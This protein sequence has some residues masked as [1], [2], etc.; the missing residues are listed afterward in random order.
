[1]RSH[2]GFVWLLVTLS[3]LCMTVTASTASAQVAAVSVSPQS[4]QLGSEVEVTATRFPAYS[5]VR[6][7]F[8]TSAG[9]TVDVT[10]LPTPLVGSDGTVR[11][12]IIVPIGL[13]GTAHI[14]VAAGGIR[15]GREFSVIGPPSP[16]P[17]PAPD[18]AISVYPSS[19]QPGSEVEV[20]GTGFPAYSYIKM[21]LISSF[22]GTTDVTPSP[23]PLADSGGNVTATFIVPDGMDDSV[24]VVIT[25]GGYSAGTTFSMGAS[26]THS[27]ALTPEPTPVPTPILTPVPTPTDAP[28]AT[29]AATTI[30]T[31][32]PMPTATL[33][34]SPQPASPPAAT[35]SPTPGPTPLPDPVP[36]PILDL[37]A[38][39]SASGPPWTII[40]TVTGV[41]SIGG[42]LLY[43]R[44]KRTKGAP[45]KPKKAPA[46]MR[47]PGPR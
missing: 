5:F 25:A 41:L 17:T 11:A 14:F 33:A 6:I 37:E 34:P 8:V 3:V 36:T 21:E 46:R 31:P 35:P 27:P 2:C 15:V 23:R 42:G 22:T 45:K 28:A 39:A 10:P 1:M 44:R 4:G 20:N 40:G 7:E 9:G 12:T 32:G 18:P 43:Y 30:P 16:T 29:P 24:Y 38:D 19:G 13:A 47:R 26:P